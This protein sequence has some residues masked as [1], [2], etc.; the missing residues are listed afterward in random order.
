MLW[1]VLGY[2]IR[3]KYVDGQQPGFDTPAR[4]DGMTARLNTH[5]A[6]SSQVDEPGQTGS[7][8]LTNSYIGDEGRG[9][10]KRLTR[11]GA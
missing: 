4:R 5:A 8:P 2:C 10:R 11:L 9:L 7:K 6:A 1:I 3:L